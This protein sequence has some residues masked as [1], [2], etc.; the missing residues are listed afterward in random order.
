MYEERGQYGQTVNGK[1]AEGWFYSQPQ[2][3]FRGKYVFIKTDDYDPCKEWTDDEKHIE[4]D[5]IY[6]QGLLE[7]LAD[8]QLIKS[9]SGED[10]KR[11]IHRL[12]DIIEKQ[13]GK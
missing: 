3:T 9:P 2:S 13:A 1:H 7:L 12:L 11:V 10:D 6:I 8:K 5:E 4:I